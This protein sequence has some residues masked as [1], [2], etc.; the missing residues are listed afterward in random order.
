VNIAATILE[1]SGVPI[2]SQMQGQSLIRIAKGNTS[3]QPIYSRNDF[4]AQAYG[5]SPMESW[6]AGKFLYIRAP[7]PELYDLSADPA[8]M[9]NLASTSKATLDTMASQLA[10]FNQHFKAT[11]GQSAQ[12]T[13]SEMQKLA[14]LGYVG[15]QKPT[16]PVSAASSGT[17]PKDA[18]AA[19]N[20]ISAAARLLE[21]G[22]FARAQ[23]TLESSMSNFANFY[24]A[25]YV[26]GSALAQQQKYPQAIQYL[27]RAIE[28][29]PDSAWAHFQMGSALLKTGD[30]KTSAVHLEIAVDRLPNF[31]TAHALLA[32][33]YEHLGKAEDAKREKAEAEQQ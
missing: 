11:P 12:L 18:I 25:Q 1:T 33:A 19:V 28:L 2:P 13:S 26:M 7:K 8:A 20:Q 24:L 3:E 29:Q 10:A 17:D 22:K 6:R 14:S 5:L 9:H 32:Q 27:H 16:T 15:V 31:F 21:T 23:Q 4:P 30:Y